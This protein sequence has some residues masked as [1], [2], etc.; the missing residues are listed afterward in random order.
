MFDA[1]TYLDRKCKGE[2]WH[3]L[4]REA[5]MPMGQLRATLEAIGR[6]RLASAGY[7]VQGTVPNSRPARHPKHHRRRPASVTTIPEAANEASAAPE[8]QP[9]PDIP[10]FERCGDD[11]PK[12]TDMYRPRTLSEVL[13]QPEIVASLQRFVAAPYSCAML[14]HGDSGIG[15]TS[16]AYALAH[17]L[18]CAVEEAELGGVFEIPSGSQTAE[19]VRKILDLLRYRPLCGSG[20]RVLMVNECDR[21]ALP[22]ETIWLD[23]LEHL[24]SM[25]VVIFTTNE[26]AR[27]SQRF[28][29]RCEEYAFQGG[30][31]RLKPWIA[32]LAQR[33]WER[34]GKGPPPDL[35]GI[36]LP[37]LGDVGSMT[38][39][40]RLGVQRIQRLLRSA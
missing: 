22:V 19:S 31:D 21:M 25:T 6:D 3:L 7:R 20:W 39:S 40:F 16:A 4:A 14:F 36:G 2:Q 27:L 11:A 17:D 32:A 10:A 15:K 5:G 23:A 30:S 9:V 37:T 29:N 28:R 38:A 1:M 18:V 12:L 13:A 8:P 33:L 35:D 24:P 34:E 26:P